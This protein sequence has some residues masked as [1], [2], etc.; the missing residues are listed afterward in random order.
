MHSFY[1]SGDV[2][3]ATNFRGKIWRLSRAIPKEITILEHRYQWHSEGELV[4]VKPP[5]ASSKKFSPYN[6]VL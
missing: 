4:G 5:M 6:L 1:R 3:M 2:A